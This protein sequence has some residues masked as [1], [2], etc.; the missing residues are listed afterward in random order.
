VITPV[1][2]FVRFVLIFQKVQL[3]FF[4]KFAADFDNQKSKKPLFERS[5]SKL[6]VKTAVSEILKS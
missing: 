2:W 5:R 1:C 3:R 6:E 4:V